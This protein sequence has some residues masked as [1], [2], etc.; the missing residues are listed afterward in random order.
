MNQCTA[1]PIHPRAVDMINSALQHLL[2]KD[3]ECKIERLKLH[4]CPD[5][6]MAQYHSI[7]T[8]FG[9]LRVCPSIYVTKG[10]AY[11]LEDSGRGEKAFAWVCRR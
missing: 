5:S 11:V 10:V 2:L 1:S 4:V 9:T 7:P 3:K 8:A 6:E